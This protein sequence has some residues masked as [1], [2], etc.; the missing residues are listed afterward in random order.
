[1]NWQPC[2]KNLQKSCFTPVDALP[3]SR[4]KIQKA[5]IFEGQVCRSDNVSVVISECHGKNNEV[6]TQSI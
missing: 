1:M 4:G 3:L 2:P 6:N 5:A